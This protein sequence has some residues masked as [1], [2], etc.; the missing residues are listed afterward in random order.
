MLLEFAKFGGANLALHPLLLP[1]GIGVDS[2]NCSPDRGDLRPMKAPL[3]VHTLPLTTAQTIYRMG[4]TAPSDTNYWFAWAADVDVARGF[5][6]EDTSERTFW[7][8]DGVPKWTDNS[9]GL[10]APPYPDSSGV[11]ILGVP[12]PNATP[13]LTETVAGSGTDESRA[14]VV[15]WVNDRGE[16]SMPSTAA[17]ITCKPGATIQVARN[18]TVPVGA[19]G[20]TKWRVYRTVAGNDE[21]YFFCGEALAA[22]ATLDTTDGMLN[23][24]DVLQS[25]DWAMPPSNLK[26][27]KVLW[28]GMMVGFVGKALCFCE[29]LYPFAWPVRYQIPLDADIVGLAKVGLSLV[30]LTVDRPYVLTGSSPEAMTPQPVDFNQACLSKRGIVEHGHGVSW[31]SPDGLCYL[32]ADGTRGVLTA[33]IATRKD[34]QALEPDTL[35]AGDDEG[36]YVGSYL[37]GGT[38]KSFTL[39]PLAPAEGFRFCDSGFVACYRDPIG[40]AFYVL[41]PGSTGAVQRWDDGTTLTAS[42]KSKVARVSRPT[43]F[44]YAQVLADSYPLTLSLW[45]DGAAVLT[46]YSVASGDGFRLPGGFLAD[47]WQ[48]Q[49]QT[50]VPVQQLLL[51]HSADELKQ[52]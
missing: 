18:A 11:R 39:N 28:G 40:D 27:L 15:V 37:V 19:Y 42:F 12:K 9:I 46:G 30:V 20:L 24:A 29:P 35:V 13:G 8:G 26:G 49:I 14:Y 32:G 6:A 47:Q 34:W 7:S 25:E 52:A 51:A 4:R 3:T 50:T 41:Q 38:H 10:G 21:D 1:D 22:T 5:I 44:G 2:R 33:S 36:L 45:A 16:P 43:N 31:P 17:T 48:F 23:S